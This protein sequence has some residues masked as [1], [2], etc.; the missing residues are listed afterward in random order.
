MQNA[1][2]AAAV[3]PNEDHGVLPFGNVGEGL[4]HVGGAR[5]LL[6]VHALNDIARLES[7]IIGRASRLNAL[8]NRTLDGSGCLNLLAYVGGEIGDADSPTR[9]AVVGAGGELFFLILRAEFFQRDKYVD[10][11][12]VAED[13]ESD[14]GSGTLGADFG[15]EFSGAG[16]FR[17]VESDDDVSNFKSGLRTGRVRLHFTDHSAVGVFQVEE[18]GVLGRDVGDAHSD[19]GVADFA[20]AYERVHDRLHDLSRNSEAHSAEAARRRDQEGVDTDDFAA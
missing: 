8:H 10:A 19:V 6:T 4:L 5:R 17:A 9:L 18:L 15:L 16:D 13:V 2:G 14:L 3:G 12:A 7:G 1:E 20:V 11:L